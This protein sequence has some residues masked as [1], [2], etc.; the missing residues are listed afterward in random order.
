LRS[1]CRIEIAYIDPETYTSIVNHDLRKNILKALY[2]QSKSGPV[3]K[4]ALAD[5]LRVG[6]HQ[7]VYQLNN[8]LKDFW[9]V[10][11]EQ[12]IR[13]TRME[14]IGPAYPDT[15]FIALGKDNGVFM[16][17]PIANL[18]GPLH[19]VGSRCD[20]CSTTESYRCTASAIQKGCCGNDPT[21]TEMAI[22]ISNNR[23]M[24]FRVV[25]H[26]ILCALRGI[27]EGN[28]CTVEIPCDGC[29]FMKKFINIR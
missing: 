21:E 6:Y 19:K 15:I 23:K 16:V 22:L 14:L 7:L 11:E 3:T 13:G 26:A 27:P 2:A 20:Q 25:D 1:N 10:M 28:T 4:Q 8:H 5:S 24:P 9:L 17:D 18:F 29:A 12:K